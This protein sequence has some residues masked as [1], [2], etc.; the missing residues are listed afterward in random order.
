MFLY[1]VVLTLADRQIK[2]VAFYNQYRKD[3]H[4]AIYN[5]M[6]LVKDLVACVLFVVFSVILYFSDQK[7]STYD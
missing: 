3:Y 6:K 2:S 1:G 7:G 5:A 4:Y